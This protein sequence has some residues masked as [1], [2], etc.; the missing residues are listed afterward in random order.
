MF[1]CHEC[2]HEW[3]GKKMVMDDYYCPVCGSGRT[4]RTEK[5]SQEEIDKLKH[6]VNSMRD[7]QTK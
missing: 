7:K 4:V 3:S 6:L 1:N 5:I 2:D